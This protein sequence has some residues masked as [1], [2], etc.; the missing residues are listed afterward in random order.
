MKA[1]LV[2]VIMS[3]IL[4]ITS[5][6][7]L[8]MAITRE[9]NENTS[10]NEV[11]LGEADKASM[12]NKAGKWNFNE[13]SGWD[14]L[15]YVS[16]NLTKLV[17]GVSDLNPSRYAKLRSTVIKHHGKIV[18]TVSTNDKIMAMTI[19]IP[20]EA[21]SPFTTEATEAELAR[22][23]EPNI[24]FQSQLVP[25]DQDWGQQWGPQKIGADW[26]WNVTIGDPSII[27][28][29]VDTGIDYN[30]P[31]LTN[32]YVSLGWDWVNDDP[33]PMDDEGHG[34]HC[35]GI[36]AAELN[37][38]IGI[39]GLA[40]VSIMAEKGLDRR[41]TGYSD[42]LANAII[43]AVN[44][45]ADIISMS[46]G[47]YYY[48][49]LI[50]EAIKYAYDSGVLLIA[51]AGN[52]GIG[53]KLFP[54]GFDEVIAV[55]A[56]DSSNRFASWSNFG[57]WVELS[58]PGVNIY[59]THLGNQ[60]VYLDGTSMAAP[61]VSG[62]AA[63]IWSQFPNMTRNWVRMQL[64]YTAKDLAPSGF[65]I[66][67]GYGRVNA[68]KAVEQTP[69]DHDLV[70]YEWKTPP[71]V[72]PGTQTI[73]NATVL[74]FGGENETD[75]TLQ[76]FANG[77]VVNS[78]IISFIASSS[79]ASTS[80]RWA[81][82][83]EG[84][85]NVSLYL[86]PKPFETI[87]TNNV[88][89]KYIYVGF[90]LKAVVLSSEGNIQSFTTRNWEEL[91]VNWDLFGSTM[92]Y[93]DYTTL[94]KENITYEDIAATCADVL[95]ISSA[96]NPEYGW[97]FTD[98]E[99]GA[100]KQ[101]VLEG[102][103][104][105]ATEATFYRLVPNN[106]KL[107]PLFGL[108]E[109]MT[110]NY[111]T[112]SVINLKEQDHPLF[113][114]I[115]NPYYFSEV[116]TGVSLDG[117]WDANELAGG[118]YVA[119]GSGKESAIVVHKRGRTY[120]SPWL[121]SLDPYMYSL[122]LQLLYNAITWS[123]HELSVSL[124]APQYLYLGESVL[125]NATVCNIGAVNETDVT[126]QLLINGTTVD[127]SAISKLESG[128][129]Y[130][131]SYLW[132]PE[133]GTYNIT[134][135]VPPVRGETYTA[136]NTLSKI[137]KVS[138]NRDV[139]ILNVSSPSA[140]YTGRKVNITVV[141]KNFGELDETFNVTVCCDS[142]PIGMQ[143]IANL[144]PGQ[145]IT[146]VFI[147]NTTGLQLG[148][149]EIWA[150]AATVQGEINTDNNVFIYGQVK[151]KMV[152]DVDGDGKIGIYDVVLAT[153]IYGSQVGDPYWNPEADGAPPWGIIN[154]YDIVV[155]TSVYGQTYEDC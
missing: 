51:A 125:L 78:T 129:S 66:H 90:P 27:V 92:I 123:P 98:S 104:I 10:L 30:H 91:S 53:A 130:T 142:T 82:I 13:T 140:V 126:L 141:A 18:D 34:T 7:A 114:R 133:E 22:Y 96:W 20:L 42:W 115:P 65:D 74:N 63:L 59:S 24:K 87:V 109:T 19:E 17:L 32:N 25:D 3:I 21:V 86:A 54:A 102:H 137:V 29:V 67:Y 12:L 121:E 60:Y 70:V 152:G 36:I 83:V 23:V 155:I 69:P 31:D 52:E 28:A 64:R 118:K 5:S 106:N 93:I 1:K 88:V 134:A 108:N 81:P 44:Q 151:I 145:N 45:S 110:W 111:T 57:E 117:K 120:I 84:K 132:A 116:T 138:Q 35:A 136:N 144:T 94:N 62:V 143:T 33:N 46:W 38:S 148:K 40:Q 50:Y 8:N 47:G 154:I 76:L 6:M 149:H 107:T 97:E 127:S 75:M 39:A 11:L 16:G 122:H 71:Y 37:N 105:I 147:C 100:I 56:T 80:M 139:G 113:H 79:S 77:I 131:L 135:H 153:S 9:S 124:N 58:A 95:I 72:E 119:L 99:I 61:H 150:E 48:S 103:G 49:E 41:G 14:A 85:Y 43:H 73:V 2:T 68:R 101:Y 112:T 26:A 15:A 4:M 89:C 146:L 55:A 128:S